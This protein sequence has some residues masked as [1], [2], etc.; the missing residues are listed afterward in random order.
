MDPNMSLVSTITKHS[1]PLKATP[2]ALT[3]HIQQ[4]SFIAHDGNNELLA[5][6]LVYLLQLNIEDM[7]IIQGFCIMPM[8]NHCRYLLKDKF[9]YPAILRL[10]L[11]VTWLTR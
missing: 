6:Q 2:F 3:I 11:V 5:S 7:W 8:D 10:Y 9:Y 1:I 4:H